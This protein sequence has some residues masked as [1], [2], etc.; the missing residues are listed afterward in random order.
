MVMSAREVE[1]VRRVLRRTM[2][3]EFPHFPRWV[4]GDSIPLEGVL[5]A[6]AALGEAEAVAWVQDLIVRWAQS[7]DRLEAGDFLAP[8]VPLLLVYER[9]GD[10]RLLDVAKQLAALFTGAMHGRRGVPLYYPRGHQWQWGAPVDVMQL[11]GP[12]LALLG[13]LTGERD[14]ATQA[15]VHL[16]GLSAALFDPCEGLFE[17][18][19]FDDRGSTTRGFWGRGQGWAL[20]GLADAL[21]YA[22][23]DAP[24]VA[25]VQAILVQHAESLARWQHESGHWRT[26]VDRPD[27]YLETSVA[28]FFAAAVPP[29]IQAGLLPRTLRDAAERAWQAALARVD[30]QGNVQGTSA[31]T[32]GG[33]VWHYARIPVGAYKWG[34][35]PFLLAAARRLSEHGGRQ[36]GAAPRV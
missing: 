26:V 8:G 21:R 23:P 13:R 9:T 15:M 11:V 20:L 2:E 34:Q 30:E 25:A 14:Y 4:W 24:G 10:R 35:G 22:P 33:D 18:W 17:H 32:A 1:V 28:C 7:V 29:A 36:A 3:S 12:F 16:L 27:V 31:G 6:G 19:H 5:A